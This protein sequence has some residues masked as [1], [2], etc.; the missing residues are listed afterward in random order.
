MQPIEKEPCPSKTGAQVVPALTVFQTPPEAAAT[1]Q[2]VG[3]RGSTATSTIRPPTTAGPMLRNSRPAKVEAVMPPFFSSG[4]A[5]FSGT[6]VFWLFLTA[7]S[8]LPGST[9]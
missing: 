7:S 9:L 4:L 2:V 6:P 1:Y 3:V 8:L 5:P